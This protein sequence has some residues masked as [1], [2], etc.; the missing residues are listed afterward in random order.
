MPGVEDSHD[1]SRFH[2]RWRRGR[3]R[4]WRSADVPGEAR[5]DIRSSIEAQFDA[6]HRQLAVATAGIGQLAKSK[7]APDLVAVAAFR[8][9]ESEDAAR[10]KLRIKGMTCRDAVLEFGSPTLKFDHGARVHGPGGGR[11]S[12]WLWETPDL[13]YELAISFEAGSATY[14]WT[15]PT[16]NAKRYIT[17]LGDE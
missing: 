8:Q 4:N 15:S 10:A 7:P 9:E 14:G 11:L 16:G 6:W 5:R 13:G 2:A 1:T 3:R 17:E 12:S